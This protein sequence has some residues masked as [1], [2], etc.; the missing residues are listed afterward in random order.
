MATILRVL[1]GFAIIV[2][3]TTLSVPPAMA[4]RFYVDAKSKIAA[5]HFS[6]SMSPLIWRS[7]IER[8][9]L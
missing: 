9:V 4:I 1:I 2:R 6:E 5:S 8:R 3:V 7:H